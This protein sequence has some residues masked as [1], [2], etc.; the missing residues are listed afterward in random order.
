MGQA[1]TLLKTTLTEADKIFYESVFLEHFFDPTVLYNHGSAQLGESIPM[2][3]GSTVDWF[4]YHP[5]AR[6]TA[7]RSEG[8]TTYTA[9][10]L[11]AMTVTAQV[12]IWDSVV[13][14]SELL[15]Y[16][17]RDGGMTKGIE[18]LSE[19]GGESVEQETVKL[20]A[21]SGCWPL[22]RNAY[23]ATTGIMVASFYQENVAATLTG[24][25][26][27][28]KSTNLASLIEANLSNDVL[29][30]G[31]GCVAK[32]RG[33]GSA[34]RITSYDSDGGGAGVPSFLFT[35]AAAEALTSEVGAITNITIAIPNHTG[36]PLDAND[37]INTGIL[38]KAKEILQKN[39]AKR[40]P[41]GTY[42]A[43][44]PPEVV[45]QLMTIDTTWV[46]QMTQVRVEKGE[47]GY[48]GTWAG[49]SFYESNITARYPIVAS[50]A[51]A[52]SFSTGEMR[53]TLIMGTNSFGKVTIGGSGLNDPKLIFKGLDTG[54]V[55][56]PTESFATMAWKIIWK[57][58]PL[59]AN[60]CVAL[61]TYFA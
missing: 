16:S 24:T 52:I 1:A 43:I 54:G 4:R 21:E 58:K 9:Q 45:T 31:F 27:T 2:N 51:N 29:I 53:T 19:Q 28:F 25:T 23:N 7:G 47:G 33:Y 22:P 56:N 35:P 20:M 60:W 37:T 10:A 14:F 32:G 49:I 38:L 8:K 36:R 26:T 30:G 44:I 15:W 12:E 5:L 18:V 48:V 13:T 61:F 59:N 39:K 3:A 34:F 57:I 17:G 6:K 40:F 55:A 42:H 41:D 50:T 11:K 46:S